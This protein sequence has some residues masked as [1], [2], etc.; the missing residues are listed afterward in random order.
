MINKRN[1]S[2]VI[3]C[4]N[5]IKIL[6]KVLPS[7]INQKHVNEII[8][9]D[10][11]SKDGTDIYMKSFMKKN[12]L[13]RYIKNKERKGTCGTKNVGIKKA[14]GDYI[15]IGEDDIELE[16]DYLSILLKHLLKNKAEVIGSRRIW[17]GEGETKK[18]AHLRTDKIK[19]SPVD[20]S[21]ISTNCETNIN[22]DKEVYLLDACMLIK[23]DVFKKVLFD[24]KLFKDPV[25]WRNETDF[26]LSVAEKGFKQIF[27][28]HTY[29]YHEPKQ[30]MKL[31]SFIKFLKYDYFVILNNYKFA[32]K[33]KEQMI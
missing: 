1:I 27:C 33:Q 21:L 31:N 22:T 30:G 26:Q 7:Y 8:I 3:A 29:C 5:R 24:T 20:Y 13:L 4:Y 25:A 2:I 16:K 18:Q 11:C 6:K 14:K 15:F 28:P 23:K 19:T 17:L 9:V 32:K 12:K 10:D